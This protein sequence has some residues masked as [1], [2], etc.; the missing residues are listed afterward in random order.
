MLQVSA[1][2]ESI[3]QLELMLQEQKQRCDDLSDDCRHRD[4]QL[5]EQSL[6]LT[7]TQALKDNLSL[8]VCRAMPS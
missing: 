2:G 5:R 1:K 4:D 7:S 3:H 6:E 8:T